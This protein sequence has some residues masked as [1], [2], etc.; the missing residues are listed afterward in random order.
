MRD[1]ILFILALVPF[2]LIGLVVAGFIAWFLYD[3]FINYRWFIYLCV[4]VSWV[5][6]AGF[7]LEQK[8][9][10]FSKI[11]SSDSE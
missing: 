9:K 7:Y 4:S 8:K 3:A 11:L 6:W 10:F 2:I 1:R 5:I